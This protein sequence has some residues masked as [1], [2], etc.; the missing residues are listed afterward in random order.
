MNVRDLQQPNDN[1]QVVGL[2]INVITS[3]LFIMVKF[4]QIIFQNIKK[5]DKMGIK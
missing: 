3:Q 5:N 4:E 2:S 1:I